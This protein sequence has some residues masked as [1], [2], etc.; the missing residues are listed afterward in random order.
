[1]DS[2]IKI[3]KDRLDAIKEEAQFDQV[4][5]DAGLFETV[6]LEA[7][8]LIL[9]F[10]KDPA[11]IKLAKYLHTNHLVSDRARMEPFVHPTGNLDL[12][13][14]TGFKGNYDNFII[15]KSPLGWVALKPDEAYLRP[16]IDTM[17]PIL[18][19]GKPVI[20][21]GERQ[22]K[23]Y[24]PLNDQ[25]LPYEGIFSLKDGERFFVKTVYGTRGGSYGK[26]EKKGLSSVADQL[27]DLG[28]GDDITAVYRL[29]ARDQPD[30]KA[31]DPARFSGHRSRTIGDAGAAVQ[32]EKVNQRILKRAELL[33]DDATMLKQVADVMLRMAPTIKNQVQTRIRRLGNRDFD[34]E[35]VN[36]KDFNNEWIRSI[37]DTVDSPENA[38]LFKDEIDK[39]K[40]A[41]PSNNY[42]NP[43]ILTILATKRNPKVLGLVIKNLR[44]DLTTLFNR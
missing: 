44:D 35:G 22:M 6:L 1:M 31:L 7:S 9:Q 38:V 12:R 21:G 11:G 34:F 17:I 3:I 18:K 8:P 13:D 23:K 28:M 26:R 30:M 24:N 33:P 14:R 15:M 16:K 5:I 40:A 42:S 43:R 41:F 37:A 25:K 10:G 2:I 29:E 19:G 39:Y 36:E 27:K 32:R 4:F 20:K